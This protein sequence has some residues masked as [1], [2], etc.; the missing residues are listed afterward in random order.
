MDSEIWRVDL[1]RQTLRKEPVP[2]PWQM[3]GGR[4]LVARILL[5]EVP[6]MCD[7]LGPFNKLLLAPGLVVGHLLSSCDRLSFGFKSPLT[8]GVKESNVGGLTGRMVARL[9]AKAIILEGRCATNDWCVLS[10][11]PGR[12]AL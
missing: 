2:K 7:P 8:R 5:D 10:S 11:E 1:D 4:G 12:S 9:G 3:T 6:P